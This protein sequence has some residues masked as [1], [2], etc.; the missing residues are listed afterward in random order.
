MIP[1]RSGYE[2]ASRL[3]ALAQ[4]ASYYACDSDGRII[5]LSPWEGL[6]LLDWDFDE[7][8]LFSKSVPD[9]Y[10]E[11]RLADFLSHPR[12]G[13][14]VQR[15]VDAWKAHPRDIQPYDAFAY[16]YCSDS[17]ITV[18]NIT[19]SG[20]EIVV[21]QSVGD[22]HITVHLNLKNSRDYADE[23]AQALKKAKQAGIILVNKSLR[24]EDFDY[25]SA[26]QDQLS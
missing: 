25:W 11:T 4:A 24:D 8:L 19:Q 16:A 17:T 7:Y 10:S 6:F 13:R 21:T 1:A 26:I 2:G 9:C 22:S 20:Y 23:V 12:G 14:T 15:Y 18:G 3:L 5:N